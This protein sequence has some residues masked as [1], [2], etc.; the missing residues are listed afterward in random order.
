MASLKLMDYS[1]LVGIHDCERPDK[2]HDEFGMED[3][4]GNGYLECSPAEEETGITCR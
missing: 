2:Y 4:D 1:L 3:G